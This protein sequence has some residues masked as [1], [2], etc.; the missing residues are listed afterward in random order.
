MTFRRGDVVLVPFPF[1]DLSAAKVRPAVVVSGALYH[2][3][4]TQSSSGCSYF[5]SGGSDRPVGLLVGRL[6]RSRFALSFGSQAGAVHARPCPCDLSRRCTDS[7]GSGT[8]RS[9]AAPCLRTIESKLH[10]LSA[11]RQNR[12]CDDKFRPP[13]PVLV[14]Q[15]GQRM[16]C[17]CASAAVRPYR[18][19]AAIHGSPDCTGGDA[20]RG[21]NRLSM[22]I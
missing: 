9:M 16:L 18:G 12:W 10:L 17:I 14:E 3:N 8:S 6:A 1:S 11:H 5:Q 22:H 13:M 20:D 21:V 4:G 2:R 7:G 15:V 19:Q